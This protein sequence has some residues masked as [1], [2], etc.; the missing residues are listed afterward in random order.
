MGTP[1]IFISYSHQ[2]EAWKDRL[3]SHLRVLERQ[4]IADVWETSDLR[5]G[6]DWATEIEKTINQS[7]IAVLLVSPSSL[8]SDFIVTQE[9][10]A[11]LKRRKKE[12]VVA[13]SILVRLSV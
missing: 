5:A 13:L 9:L 4:G 3:L 6:V 10:P 12:G 7:D 11:L 2:D 8:A 1:K